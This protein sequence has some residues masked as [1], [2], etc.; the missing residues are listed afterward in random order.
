MKRGK[1]SKQ[2]N[3][4]KPQR[5]S[6][7]RSTKSR[8]KKSRISRA[9]SRYRQSFRRQLGFEPLED[10]SLLAV[11]AAITDINPNFSDLDAVDPD[12]GSGGRVN[13]LATVAGNNQTF[14]AASEFGGIYRTTDQGQNWTH[15]SGHLPQVTWDVEVDPSNA[16]RIYATSFYDS[17]VNPIT[18]IQVSTDGGTIWAHPLTAD[19][20][21]TFEGTANDN[22]PQVGYG[23]LGGATDTARRTEPSAFGISIRPTAANNVAIGTNAGVAI[24]NDSGATWQFIDP[25][26][27]TAL[28]DV[29]DV[30]WHNDGSPNGVIDVV[31]IDG[32]LRSTDGGTT[33]SSNNLPVAGRSIVVSPDESYVLVVAGFDGNLYESDDAGATWTNL[34]RTD[35]VRGGGRIPFVSVNDTTAGFDVWTGGVS[36]YRVAGT[37]PAVPAPGGANRLP[38][39]GTGLPSAPAGWFGG[40]TRSGLGAAT[41][42]HDDI[43]DIVFDATQA[44]DAVPRMFS[45]DGGVYFAQTT[46]AAPTSTANLVWQQPTTTPHGHWLYGFDGV[47]KPG[48]AA[49]DIYYGTQDAGSFAQTNSGIS[50]PAVNNTWHNQDCCD[51]DDVA[52]EDDTVLYSAGFFGGARGFLLFL[53]TT[54]MATS[55][56]V[57]TYPG[58]VPAGATTA[59]SGGVLTSFNFAESMDTWG[60]DA[61]AVLTV[62]NGAF[63]DGGL[64][65]TQNIKASPIVWT[66]LVGTGGDE[67]WNS[68]MSA[69]VQVAMSGGIPTFFVQV[70]G[71]NSRTSDQLWRY[72]GTNPTTGT[73][74]QIDNNI[75]GATGITVWSVDPNNPNFVY[76]SALTGSGPQI[77]FS[78]DS[79]VNW[80]RDT[81]LETMMTGGG[82]FQFQNTRGPTEFTSFGGYPQ[83]TLLAIDPN[84]PQNIVAGGADSGVF[85]SE[86]GG[87][88]WQLLTDPL[89]VIDNPG[90][91]Q[92]DVPHLPRP[93]FAHFDSESGYLA[94]LFIGTQGRGV[95]RISLAPPTDPVVNADNM[96]NNILVQLNALDSSIID[97]YIDGVL[98]NSYPDTINS[99]TINGLGSADTLTV[100]FVNGSP[101]PTGGIDYDGGGDAGDQLTLE[102]STPPAF[103]TVTYYLDAPGLGSV[104]FDALGSVQD[105]DYTGLAPINDNMSPTNR[106]FD[107]GVGNDTDVRL[108]DPTADDN[109]LR[110]EAPSNAEMVNFSTASLATIQVNL[111]TGDDVMEIER[112]DTDDFSGTITVNGEDGTDTLQFDY[113]VGLIEEDVT[114]NGGMTGETG[115]GDRLLLTGDPAIAIVRETYLVGGSQDAGTWIVDADDSQGPG[116][117]GASAA[118]GD[119]V[120]TFTGLEPADT[121]VT[122]VLNFDVIMNGMANDATIADGFASVGFTSP[123]MQVIDNNATF[124]SFRFANKTTVRIMGQSGADV[125]DLNYTTAAAGLTTLEV[126]GHVAPGVV[127]QPADDDASDRFSLRATDAVTNSL[128]GQG[129]SD[130][131]DNIGVAGGAPAANT[132]DGLNGTINITGGETAGDNDVSRLQDFADTSADNVTIETVAGPLTAITGAAPATINSSELEV[133]LFEGTNDTTTADTIDVLGTLAGTSYYITG[134]GGPDVIT[135]GNESADFSVNPDGSLASDGGSMV[136]I[137][138]EIMVTGE[139]NPATSDIDTLNIDASGDGSLAGAATLDVAPAFVGPSLGPFYGTDSGAATELTGFAPATIRYR[140][141]DSSFLFGGTNNIEFVNIFGSDGDDTINVNATTAIDTTR[142]DVHDGDDFNTMTI[143]GDGLSADN[144]F[145][146]SAGTD[147]FVLNI[148]T[149]LGSGSFVD[150]TSLE[151]WGDAPDGAGDSSTRDRLEINDNSGAAR[152][153]VF[154]YLDSLTGDIDINPGA[155]GGLGVGVEDIPVNVRTMETVDYN[156]TGA[157]DTV[158]VEGTNSDDDITV[159]PITP[160]R[161]MVFLGGDPFDGPPE[162]FADSLPGVAGGSNG[163]DLDLNGLA[164]A[165]GLTIDDPD[166]PA[167]GDRL[168]IYGQSETGLTDPVAAAATF[169]PFGFGVGLILPI[170]AVPDS[171][172]DITVNDTMT[173]IT[174]DNGAGATLLRVN[175]NTVDFVQALPNVDPAIV[176]NAGEETTNPTTPPPDADSDVITLTLSTEYRFQINGNDPDPATTSVV[177]PAGDELI[178]PATFDTINV[179]SNKNPGGQP[180]VQFDFPGSGLMGFGYSSI[181]QLPVFNANTVNLIGDNNDPMVDQNDNFVVVGADVDGDPTDGGYQEFALVINGSILSGDGLGLIRFNDVQFLNVYGDDQNPPPGM[182]S[183]DPDIDT[184]DIS[185]YADDTPR[186]WGIDVFFDEGNPVQM[187]GDQMDLLIYRTSM[188]GGM[189][190]EDIVIQPAGP[191]DGEIVVTNAGFG[192]PIVDIDF[193]NN[194]DIIVLDDDGFDNDTDSLTL[195]GIS[196]DNP[197]ASGDDTFDINFGAAGTLAAPMVTVTDTVST[198]ISYRLRTIDDAGGAP[199]FTEV[200]FEGLGGT[201]VFNVTPDADVAIHIDGGDPIG[202][203]QST[204]DTLNVISGGAS[205]TFQPG[206]E[207]DSGTITVT[208]SQP[209]SFDE[210][211]LLQVDGITLLL[212]D[213]FEPNDT[214]ATSTVLGSLPQ[215]TLQDLTIHATQIA[216]PNAMPDPIPGVTNVDWFKITANETGKLIVNA[217]FTDDQTPGDGDNGNID[218]Q[219]WDMAGNNITPTGQGNSTTD[220]EQIIIPVVSQQ[221]Y[222]LRVFSVADMALGSDQNSYDLEIENFAA[223][224]PTGVVLDPN[225]DSGMMNNDLITLVDNARLFVKADLQDFFDEGITI[226]SAAQA[227]AGTT[228][229]ATVEVF[230]NGASVGFADAFLSTNSLFAITL[231]VTADAN[232]NVGEW[233]Q[234]ITISTGRG[235][236]NARVVAVDNSGYFNIVE[237]AVRIF[238]GQQDANG[239]PASANART[240]L[241]EELD[242]HFDPNA[243]DESLATI[244]LLDASD[245]NIAGDLTTAKMSPAFSGVAEA[246]TKVRIFAEISGS[247]NVELVGQGV[248]GSD[249][250]DGVLGDGLGLWEVTVEPLRD[251]T[252]NITAELEDIAGN[253]SGRTTALVLVVDTLPPQRP[254]VD[255][256][257]MDVQDQLANVDDLPMITL[258]D[259]ILSD[260]GMDTMDNVTRGVDPQNPGG[261]GTTDVQLRIS[262]EPGTEVFVKDGEEVIATFT[263]PDEPFVF[264]Y[265][266]DILDEDPHPISVEAFDLA[267]NRSAQSEELLITVDVTPP[268]TPAA[269]NL[270][271]SSDTGMFDDD[272]VTAKWT[273]VFD[274]VAEKNTKVRVFADLYVGGVAQGTPILVGQGMVNSDE[275]DG[276]PPGDPLNGMGT[277][278]VQADALADGV[279]DITIELEDLAGNISASSAALQIEIDKIAPNTPFLDL[280]DASDTGRHDDDNITNDNTPAVSVTSHDPNAANHIVPDA[281][282]GNSTDYLKFR[283]YDRFE[284]HTPNGPLE[285][286]FLLYDSATDAGP[287]AINTAGDM[288]TSATL[289]DAAN[290]N[291]ANLA[292]QIGDAGTAVVGSVLQDGIHSLKVEVEDRAG[293]ISEDFLIDI[294]VDTVAPPKSFGD[295]ADDTDGLHPDSDSGVGGQ[296]N[297]FIDRITNDVT[298]T[299]FGEAEANT[300][301]R[302]FVVVDTGADAADPD[303]DTVVA[304]GEAVAIPTDGDDALMDGAWQL[305]STVSMNDLVTLAPLTEDGV[306]TIRITGEDVAGNVSAVMDL[307]IFIDTRGP[308][309]DGVFVTDNRDYDLFDPK[310]STDGPTPL[311]TSIDIDLID[312]PVRGYGLTTTGGDV[313]ALAIGDLLGTVTLPGSAG[314]VGGGMI[315]DGLGGVLFANP[316]EGFFASSIGLY[317]PPVG[318]D[319][320]A[321]LVATKTITNGVQISTLT[322]DS[323]REILWGAANDTVYQID[324][325]DPFTSSD[326]TADFSFN[327]GVGGLGLV[328]G[329][330]YDPDRDTLWYSPD[331]NQ[332]VYEFGLG[333]G[334]A[335]TLG[336]LLNTVA[337]ENAA[338]T[339]DGL[340]SGV[341]VGANSTLYIGR[342]GA[343]EIR[344]IQKFTGEFISQ[345]SQTFGRAEDLSCDP[346]TYAPLEAIISKELTGV[347]TYEAFEVEPGTCLL[348][349]VTPTTGDF[350]YPAVNEIQALTAGNIMVVGDANGIIAIESIEFIDNTVDGEIGQTTLRVNFVDALPDDRFTLTIMDNLMDDAGNFLDGESNAKEPQEDPTFPSGDGKPGGDFIARFTVDT[351]P[352]IG[353]YCCGSQYIDINGNMVW[354]PVGKDNDATNQ[355]LVFRFGESTDAI[356]AGQFTPAGAATADGFDR[357]GAYGYDVTL[358]MYRFLLDFDNDGVPDPLAAASDPDPAIISGV[359]VNAIPV[360]GDFNLAK[361]GDE[362]GIFDGTTWYLDTSGN[363]N[364]EP[365]EAIPT[366]MRGLPIVGDFDGDGR[367]DLATYDVG[368]GVF[369]F[370]LFAV[371]GYGNGI[372]DTIDYFN[373]V[374]L[375]EVPVAADFNR[376]GVDDIGLFVRGRHGQPDE[377]TAEWYLLISDRTGP[378]LPSNLFDRFSPDPL[379]NDQFKMFG[380]ESAQPVVGNFDPPVAAAVDPVDDPPPP[381]GATIEVAGTDGDDDIELFLNDKTFRVT[382]NSVRTNYAPSDV[383]SFVLTDVQ[384]NDSLVVTAKIA[385]IKA[386]LAP[387]SLTLTSA[388]VHVQADG[389]E[390]IEVRANI[391]TANAVTFLDSA[392]NDR[393]NADPDS[394][395][396]KGDGFNTKAT[397]FQDVRATASAGGTSDRAKLRDSDGADQLTAQPDVVTLSGAGYSIVV[398]SFRRVF[399]TATDGDDGAEFTDSTGNDRFTAKPNW[400]RMAGDGYSNFA[401]G[402]DRYTGEAS[403]G[404]DDDQ[405]LIFDSKGVDQL[406]A[407][408]DSVV[409]AGAGFELTADLFDKVTIR[410]KMGGADGAVFY[411]SD[412]NDRF[413]GTPDYSKLVGPG[414]YNI[415]YGFSQVTAYATAGGTNDKADAYD[416]IGADLFRAVGNTFDMIG[417]GS[418][419][420]YT[421]VGFDRVTVHGDN[422]GS[423]KLEMDAI[424]F[425]FSQ[426]GSW[427]E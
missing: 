107:F 49:E 247:G 139:F 364:V 240:Q 117:A 257:G 298:P 286:E 365:A 262:A 40:F 147:N 98:T 151:I 43:G 150:L 414:Y 296:P 358:G 71:G 366:I 2:R 387:G 47:D 48:L 225:D 242:V 137:L 260:T 159:A 59:P 87:S 155:G 157:D 313:G 9:L 67:P 268:A 250:S 312:L 15:L 168:Y 22:T 214:L 275:T 318:G 39:G 85:L 46:S 426:E 332:N 269:P 56:Q 99:L 264:L 61:Y 277:W 105:I 158:V 185:P 228:A 270:Q 4:N 3:M 82:V 413:T 258:V 423:N 370:D 192:T 406:T 94:N 204:G 141:T 164:Q 38:V 424:D 11:V 239:M 206:P 223:P 79:G 324:I 175:Y 409:L 407:R 301:I 35:P 425:L 190:S 208:G 282:R 25:T 273:P 289:L 405:A 355:D 104:E 265:L 131:F 201:D 156:G 118:T 347:G 78:T 363:N 80:T 403:Q 114:F 335:G 222:F 31:G 55:T 314:G 12:G 375:T 319:G 245:T 224:V 161:G 398:E 32:H 8:K 294:L 197:P 84:N 323:N 420:E 390:D 209:I 252:Y 237:A 210:I 368:S 77:W 182:P 113:S 395:E 122:N 93:R 334:S 357:F 109:L 377:E 337:P 205:F 33:W 418:D 374:G 404:G 308:Q 389:I 26:P 359:Q 70:G 388:A 322:W 310:P 167:P 328:D 392:G 249:S 283:I 191:E 152:D 193:V 86:D 184:L 123:N 196:P 227:N 66:E 302:A 97:V 266:D 315:P 110:I 143:N 30:V 285:A 187:D 102:D 195:R 401:K 402:F 199:T 348:P 212:P 382:V 236:P 321:T 385:D 132:L 149:N 50:S 24:S 29:W 412:G 177:P 243:P 241:S 244:D 256:V 307:D 115:I 300:L 88:T 399:V 376:D 362:I 397:G 106:I 53:G 360:A 330:A 346:V 220:N 217:F 211:E 112:L 17:R 194:L 207:P 263:M 178:V 356:F 162:V 297:L 279:Y 176:V 367:D 146:G 253:V 327:P 91:P 6:N 229:G 272:N 116:G 383:G 51:V 133:L 306:R 215:V 153:L 349:G 27:A 280:D 380:D 125:F 172:D 181:E 344:H 345:F 134:N 303:D 354:D 138:G 379:G 83:P 127:G 278:E 145:H 317:R 101:I 427:E 21:P 135:I 226:L 350:V 417:S 311:V 173:E 231:D 19:P 81:N 136:A 400:A 186:G 119:L 415:A 183:M 73:W 18:G 166:G 171:R 233:S 410:S 391:G 54:G 140:H 416:G 58:N 386:V 120:I 254:T 281:Q 304:I 393:F 372:D 37:T 287:D 188:F 126:Y 96:G 142:I 154:D 333:A 111:G 411:D 291:L 255:L 331:V 381:A 90:T 10:R 130:L 338:G 293:N 45:N 408:P 238:D 351:R 234:A 62:D 295:P 230:V 378:D 336:Q 144:I 92:D 165:T 213:E 198:L 103:T 179:Y 36:L 276:L 42:A 169:D 203:L 218:I 160:N 202:A 352:E 219:I 129:G 371:G 396:M 75:P 342:D 316:Q 232:M 251:D 361:A 343:Q 108:F 271:A 52:A 100:D 353:V 248:V 128:F 95:F 320:A 74:T 41:G 235:T 28:S 290:A 421:G 261:Q 216:D 384:G 267:G 174:A 89:G 76:A 284:A 121:D 60:N 63:G 68:A 288:F 299:F 329:I 20:D 16:N 7:L 221:M 14:Y 170:V 72:T 200:T 44:I 57:N 309:V 369:S 64:H 34:G 394:A 305:T 1:N 339:A 23:T 180:Q 246:N 419:Y 65:I 5:H 292:A 373:F 189:V 69:E 259:P 148:T 124:E 325:G 274:G 340:V 163:P 326:V 422:G 13:G 341:T